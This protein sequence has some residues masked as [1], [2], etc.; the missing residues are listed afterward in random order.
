MLGVLLEDEKLD[1]EHRMVPKQAKSFTLGPGFQ[2]HFEKL[3]NH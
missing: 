2:L 3:G 1:K